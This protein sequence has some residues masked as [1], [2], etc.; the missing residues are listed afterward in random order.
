MIRRRY[1]T[2][3]IVVHWLTAICVGTAWLLSEGGRAVRQDPPTWHFAFGLAVLVLVM[4]RLLARLAGG[5]PPI[6]P[7]GSALLRSAA[8]A[9]H[10]ALYALLV[11]L[12]L[13]GWYA[14]S[15][16]GI[17]VTL[18]G[19]TLPALATPTLGGGGLIGDLHSNGGNLL[20]I[21][22]GLHGLMA[23]YHHFVLKDDTLRRMSPV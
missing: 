5:A 4:P 14:A 17:P 20:L 22:A 3:M 18:L 10:A 16:M 21:L 6:A 12:P 13:S 15:S 1:S 9:G 7:E 19:I 8:R 11:A 23:L 2:L